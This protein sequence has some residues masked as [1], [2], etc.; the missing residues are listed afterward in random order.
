MKTRDAKVSNKILI[1]LTHSAYFLHVFPSSFKQQRTSEKGP[2][3]NEMLLIVVPEVIYTSLGEGEDKGK[4]GGWVGSGCS[5][6]SVSHFNIMALL[7]F[8]GNT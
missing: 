4:A 2:G 7:P 1:H 3:R 5:L 6:G 8:Q